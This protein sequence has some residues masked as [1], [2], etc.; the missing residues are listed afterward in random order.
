MKRAVCVAAVI[1]TASATAGCDIFSAPADA[2]AYTQIQLHGN[3]SS[4]VVGGC[5][6]D[7]A[8]LRCLESALVLD[9][10]SVSTTVAE[11]PGESFQPALRATEGSRES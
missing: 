10:S 8:S 9:F 5:A 11:C 1:A 4:C 7:L 6:Y 2:I 3:C